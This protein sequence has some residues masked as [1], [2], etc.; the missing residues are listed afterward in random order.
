MKTRLILLVVIPA[1]VLACSQNR[2]PVDTVRSPIAMLYVGVPNSIVYAKA[3]DTTNAI[4]KYGYREAVS[5][6]SKS[7]DWAEVRMWDGGSGWVR[8]S[9]LM[10]SSD[11]EAAEKNTMPRFFKEPAPVPQPYAHGEIILE[12]KVNTDGQVWNVTTVKNTTR[13]T[14]LVRQNSEAL[15]AALFYPMI[16]KGQRLTFSYQHRINY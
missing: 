8:A 6:L 4:S 11:A 12:A 3:G 13:N 7:G 2:K 10:S 9:D 1:L 14:E 5:V 15:K 16:Q